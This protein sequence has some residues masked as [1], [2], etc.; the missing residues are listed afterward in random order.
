MCWWTLALEMSGISRTNCLPL[1]LFPQRLSSS[2]REEA[3]PGLLGGPSENPRLPRGR[4]RSFSPWRVQAGGAERRGLRGPGRGSPAC[5]P[6]C[7]RCRSPGPAPHCPRSPW[8]RAPPGPALPGSGA[9]CLLPALPQAPLSGPSRT[10]G[11]GRGGAS[12]TRDGAQPM[13]RSRDAQG[14]LRARRGCARWRRAREGGGGRG[15]GTGRAEA[16][17]GGAAGAAPGLRW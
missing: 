15:G 6:R 7:Q 8:P 12:R 9:W 10:S 2:G 1:F 4:V 14:R 11:R 16:E 17:P 3:R 5:C 13:A